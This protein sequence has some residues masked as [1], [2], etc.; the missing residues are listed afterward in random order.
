VVYHD[1][2]T[3]NQL[4]SA[5]LKLSHDTKISDLGPKIARQELKKFS[6]RQN[7]KEMGQ[8]QA[9]L[10]MLTRSYPHS[11]WGGE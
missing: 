6:T 7:I 2:I 10:D 8:E 1:E 11:Q 3:R 5:S 9:H 4:F